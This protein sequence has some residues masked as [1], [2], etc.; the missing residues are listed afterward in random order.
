MIWGLD[1][2]VFLY[3][4]LYQ[5]RDKGVVFSGNGPAFLLSNLLWPYYSSKGIRLANSL[6]PLATDQLSGKGARLREL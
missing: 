5:S 2:H 6:P 3:L 4:G 1:F